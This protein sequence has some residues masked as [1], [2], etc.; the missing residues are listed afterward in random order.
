MIRGIRYITRVTNNTD[1]IL[2]ISL[3]SYGDQIGVLNS[4]LGQKYEVYNFVRVKI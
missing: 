2:L 3:L 1:L 4:N